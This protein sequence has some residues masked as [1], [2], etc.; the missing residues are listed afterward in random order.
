MWHRERHLGSTLSEA[1]HL[2]WGVEGVIKKIFAEKVE[3]ET[4]KN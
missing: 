1:Q 3:S 2:C 4:W